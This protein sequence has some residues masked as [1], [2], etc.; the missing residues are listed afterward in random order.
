[1]ANNR[2]ISQ[3]AG[4]VS[5]N[6]TTNQVTI[7]STLTI[8]SGSIGIGTNNPTAPLHVLSSS[9]GVRVQRGTQSL[10]INANYAN[11]SHTALESTGD[12]S[13]FPGG[14]SEKVRITTSGIGIGTTSP[15]QPLDI[16]SNAS[17]AWAQYIRM[18]N[19]DD[20]GFLGWRSHKGTED[21]A[22]LGVQRSASNKGEILVYTNDGNASSS[23]RLRI[24]SQGSVAIGATNPSQR[25]LW[26]AGYA[27][28]QGFR[29]SNFTVVN[30]QP[31]GGNLAVD[32][33]LSINQF[34]YGGTSLMIA[35]RNTSS[36]TSTTSALYFLQWYY[37]GNNA[38]SVTLLGGSDFITFGVS[39]SNTLTV[40]GAAG[41]WAV[42]FILSGGN[43]PF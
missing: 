34:S 13:F 3:F 19:L 27:G 22:Q 6:D 10:T 20:Y 29:L 25:K 2:E 21:I 24:N 12:L 39:G 15:Q 36:G 28:A 8:P 31:G 23:E 14:S 42:T 5:V 37:D 17:G 41:N 43:M 30:T 7:G 33:G 38:P 32:T 26:V 40:N 16:I 4:L 1:M 18:R 11:Q 35:H 9:T